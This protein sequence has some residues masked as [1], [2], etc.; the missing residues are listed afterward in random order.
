MYF[1]SKILTLEYGLTSNNLIVPL[2]N[3]SLTI[4]PATI[5]IKIIINKEYPEKA[6]NNSD[7]ALYANP[8]FKL[9]FPWFEIVPSI[10]FSI[11]Y[12]AIASVA[13]SC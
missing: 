9:E 7:L 6:S 4:V 3:S 13:T 2:L 10:P 8:Y 12:L 1:E 11:A 5:I